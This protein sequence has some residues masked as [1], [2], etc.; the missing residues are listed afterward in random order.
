ML[1]ERDIPNKIKHEAQFE[2]RIRV[3]SNDSKETT[4][5]KCCKQTAMHSVITYLLYEVDE[6]TWNWSSLL[7]CFNLLFLDDFWSSLSAL[8]SGYW[9]YLCGEEGTVIQQN[10]H[11]K[12]NQWLHLIF[13]LK[14]LNWSRWLFVAHPIRP[15][16]CSFLCQCL[17]FKQSRSSSFASYTWLMCGNW[18]PSAPRRLM[19]SR[20]TAAAQ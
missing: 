19:Y 20:A 1:I 8:I 16:Q 6:W 11:T 14:I 13:P 5:S 12:A 9:Y 7:F 4:W 17:T 3:E 15:L 2:T 10:S 18:L